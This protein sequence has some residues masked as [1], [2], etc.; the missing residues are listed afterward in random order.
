MAVELEIEK[1]FIELEARI[2]DLQLTS[3]DQDLELEKEI[4]RLQQK[5]IEVLR[6]AYTDLKP[7][8]IVR[9]ARHPERPHGSD[10]IKHLIADFQPLAGDRIGAEDAAIMGGLGS[11]KGVPVMVLAIDKGKTTEERLKRNFGMPRPSGYRK[12]VRLMDLADRFRLPLLTFV[13][14]AGAHPGVDAE[15]NGQSQAIASCIEKSLNVSVPVIATIIGEGGSGG[16]VALAAADVVLMLEHAIYSVIS[17]ESCAAILWRTKEKTDLA[18]AALRFTSKDLKRLQVVDQ[19]ISEPP[20]AAHRNA[21]SVMNDVGEAIQTHLLR[22]QKQGGLPEAR[23]K[24][25]EAIGRQGIRL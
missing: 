22:L 18:A 10:Y 12:A 8:D 17:P 20:G 5:S 15:E 9:I 3:K 23:H 21:L 1:P 13:D 25:F 11:F 19:I 6:Q 7:M 4:K 16:A 2:K 14:T 24:R